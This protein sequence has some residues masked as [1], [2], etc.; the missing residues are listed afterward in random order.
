MALE[1]AKEGVAVGRESVNTGV[2]SIVGSIEQ[3]TGLKLKAIGWAQEVKEEVQNI[4]NGAQ[5]D[6]NE[7]QKIA[8][9]TI[10]S[11]SSGS[12]SEDSKR[13]V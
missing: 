7:V 13:L 2:K 6:I 1:R 9:G 5:K 10:D 11:Q 3:G 12:N 4:A 8:D